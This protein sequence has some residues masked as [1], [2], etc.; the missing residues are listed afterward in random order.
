[1]FASLTLFWAML[2][3]AEGTS[4]AAEGTSNADHW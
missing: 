1:M 2:H 3:A 4:Y